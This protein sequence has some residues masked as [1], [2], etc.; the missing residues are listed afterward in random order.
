MKIHDKFIVDVDH[1]KMTVLV[2]TH[3]PASLW[4]T[5]SLSGGTRTGEN[6]RSGANCV[7]AKSL[8][9]TAA[10]ALEAWVTIPDLM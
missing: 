10:E 1:E 8:E 3:R 9:L 5:V 4:L 2:R 6:V 7:W